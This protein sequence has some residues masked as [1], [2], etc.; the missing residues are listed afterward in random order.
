MDNKRSIISRFHPLRNK[1]H[2][3]TGTDSL[4]TSTKPLIC[5]PLSP[6][7]P[8]SSVPSPL[9]PQKLSPPNCSPP[10]KAP[11]NPLDIPEILY[12]IGQFITLWRYSEQGYT[13]QFVPGALVRCTCV[14]RH[15]H[16]VMTPIIWYFYDDTLMSSIPYEVVH[17]NAHFIKVL[18]HRH[19]YGG[20]GYKCRNLVQLST[21][22][23][24]V[25]AEDLIK[26]NARL[27]KFSWHTHT[28]FLTIRQPIYD[29]LAGVRAGLNKSNTSGL[30]IL[31]ILE[32]EGSQL[33]PRQL[34][35]LLENH[36]PGLQILILHNV[37]FVS[38]ENIRAD[39]TSELSKIAWNPQAQ[40]TQ[41]REVRIGKGISRGKRPL[42]DILTH[43]P[44]LERLVIEGLDESWISANNNHQKKSTD[45]FGLLIDN[46]E[47]SCPNLK[48]IA[49][50]PH[51]VGGQ[52]NLLDDAKYTQLIRCI[53]PSTRDHSKLVGDSSRNNGIKGSNG[54]EWNGDRSR[55][56]DT[57]R[58]YVI[59]EEENKGYA[60]PSFTA[61]MSYLDTNSTLALCNMSMAIESIALRLHS[62]RSETTARANM[63]NAHQIL[64]SCRALK[65][66]TL[67][68]EALLA[69]WEM[70]TPVSIAL[71]LYDNPWVCT[72]LET[73]VIDGVKRPS[74]FGMDREL[75]N[76][77]SRLGGTKF[78]RFG[79]L[80]LRMQDLLLLA[81]L[82]SGE[83]AP[84]ISAVINMGYREALLK[85][86][87]LLQEKLFHQLARLK[88]MR[89]LTWNG[90]TFRDFSK[91]AYF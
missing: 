36:L 25:G 82:G 50:S 21:S 54:V 70:V 61:D 46:L 43:C 3:S 6:V 8:V 34:F 40:F 26:Q 13:P 22:P 45:L 76:Q 87:D 41:I 33:D 62:C 59:G 19:L 85:D 7:S 20:V 29:A 32:F 49:Y 57:S 9:S 30:S 79:C 75:V 28:Y 80:L 67:E 5:S 31:R 88:N 12:R 48:S 44:R 64:T 27:E 84:Q 51:R 15:W 86:I 14:S 78:N 68:H 56:R 91:L 63:L 65:H 74:D 24:V 18:N 38:E 52:T 47:Q 71:L 60:V 90:D 81:G 2:I 83:K 10:T 16:N 37:T 42:I 39:T 89:Q 58:N 69:P 53:D 72:R 11:V 35:P 66:F 1:N 4:P 55:N 73:L 23:W 77:A 17:R